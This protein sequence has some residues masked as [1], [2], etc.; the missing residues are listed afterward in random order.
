VRRSPPYP[1]P[2]EA[3]KAKKRKRIGTDLGALSHNLPTVP[4]MEFLNSSLMTESFV[5]CCIRCLPLD[6]GVAVQR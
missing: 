6:K 5:A 4:D 2:E 1:E 3:E